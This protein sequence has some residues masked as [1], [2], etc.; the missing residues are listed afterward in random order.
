MSLEKRYLS[1]RLQGPLQSWGFNSRFSQRKT[2]LFPT[3]SA[4]AG[5]CCGALG[6][7]RGSDRE[8]AFLRQFAN[9]DF[10][11]VA[12]PRIL[13]NAFS[14]TKRQ[15][16]VSRMRDYH[17][18]Q[19][20]RKADGG[21]KD[22][23]ITNREFLTDADFGGVLFGERSLIDMIANA[24][25]NPIWGVWLGRKTCIPTAPIFVGLYEDDAS[26]FMPLIGNRSVHE[27]AGQSDCRQFQL[28]HD[29]IPD[30]ASNFGTHTRT[31]L[32]RRVQSWRGQPCE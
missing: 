12:I 3:K 14:G 32:P 29:S 15:V 7:D 28:A 22:C 20:T 5:L 8:E 6:I 25:K 24:L 11:V 9:I 19:G 18:V 16:S 23:Q 10:T 1:M 21:T 30:N 27:F 31:F 2:G 26:A 17:T 13:P 4:I